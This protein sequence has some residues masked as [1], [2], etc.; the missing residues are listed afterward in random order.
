MTPPKLSLNYKVHKEEKIQQN[1]KGDIG[2][3]KF[4]RELKEKV[5]AQKEK[6]RYRRQWTSNTLIIELSKKKT[7]R[8]MF[9]AII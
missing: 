2:T 5:K 7:I 8:P 4:L 1:I 9:K 6:N 3:W